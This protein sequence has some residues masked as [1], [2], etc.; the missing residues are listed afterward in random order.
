MRPS[1]IIFLVFFLCILPLAAVHAGQARTIR[2][3]PQ[4]LDAVLRKPDAKCV[5]V[6]MASWCGPCKAAIPAVNRL[7]RKYAPKGLPLYGISLDFSGPGTFDP[8]IVSHDIEFPVYWAGESVIEK[9]GLY[10]VP[11]VVFFC[12]GE[13]V[14]RLVGVQ[15]E[16][17]L[18]EK[19]RRFFPR[20]CGD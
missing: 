17:A 8:I 10:P 5:A 6:A 13:I 15:K 4:E 20:I 9:Y 11:M 14:D 7:Y 19:F 1:T 18:Q 16:S 3:T 2:V 12:N